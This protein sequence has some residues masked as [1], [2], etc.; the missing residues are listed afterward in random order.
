[1]LCT[2][3]Y[4]AGRCFDCEISSGIKRQEKERERER[5]KERRKSENE[6]LIPNVRL[7]IFYNSD[8]FYEMQTEWWIVHAFPILHSYPTL[9]S[10]QNALRINISAILNSN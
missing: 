9:I 1:M 10:Q 7:T 2:K 6:C 4:H 5:E 8:F 3:L